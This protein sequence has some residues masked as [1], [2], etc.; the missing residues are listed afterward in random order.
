MS[1]YPC[2]CNYISI[3]IENKIDKMKS[4]MMAKKMANPIINIRKKRR[5][6][7]MLFGLQIKKIKKIT[8]DL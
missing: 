4:K 7:S 6:V 2:A 3:S 8:K 5:E 1:K